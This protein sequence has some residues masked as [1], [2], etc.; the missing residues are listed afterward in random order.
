MIDEFVETY[1]ENYTTRRV[2]TLTVTAGLVVAFVVLWILLDQM[3]GI[4]FWGVFLAAIAVAFAVYKI[5]ALGWFWQPKDGETTPADTSSEAK[6]DP[7]QQLVT[8]EADETSVSSVAEETVTSPAAEPAPAPVEH[9]G[10][11]VPR[12]RPLGTRVISHTS[13]KAVLEVKTA[14]QFWS[15]V[16]PSLLLVLTV[17]A[18][19]VGAS[20]GVAAYATSPNK[21]QSSATAYATQ[22]VVIIAGVFLGLTVLS[23][24]LTR[25][26]VQ[27]YITKDVVFFGEYRFDRELSGG[28][29]IG[30]DAKNVNLPQSFLRPRFGM[31]VLRFAYGRWGEDMRYLID[32]YQANN[33]VVWMNE[34]I[35]SIGDPPTRRFDPSAGR[36]IELL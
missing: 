10:L 22:S 28:F 34:I 19:P 5:P 25:P 4:G 2:E 18:I 6:A 17:I 14:I 32:A 24:F 1:R 16:L 20:L 36:K 35:D 26:K 33:I 15:W 9:L 29:R 13:D 3:L 21:W 27:V 31:T 11:R 12:D 7:T 23:Y 30:Y 8:D